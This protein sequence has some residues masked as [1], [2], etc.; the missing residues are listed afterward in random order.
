MRNLVRRGE[1]YLGVTGNTAG[2]PAGQVRDG[3]WVH[4]GL[5]GR[6]VDAPHVDHPLDLTDTQTEAGST[7]HV[8][9]TTVLPAESLD[10]TRDLRRGRK[11]YLENE[12]L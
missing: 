11:K 3:L 5:L 8:L 10:L 2:V 4:V 1:T 7:H 6:G 9:Q 12:E